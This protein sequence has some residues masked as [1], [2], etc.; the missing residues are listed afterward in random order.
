MSERAREWILWALCTFALLVGAAG[1]R[2]P[3][4]RGPAPYPP[5]WQSWN[6]LS[7]SGASLLAA[8]YVLPLLYLGWSLFYG[9]RA[10]ANPWQATGLEWT[11]SSPP[12]KHNFARTPVV[13]TEPYAYEPEDGSFTTQDGTKYA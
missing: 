6:L 1:D 11:T 13:T 4:L 10:G 3:I 12:P 9:R 8:A 2:V 7:S 5:E